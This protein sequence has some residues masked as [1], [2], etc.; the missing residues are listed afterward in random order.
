MREKARTEPITKANRSLADPVLAYSIKGRAF[1]DV[2]T[3][4]DV[5]GVANELAELIADTWGWN[6]RCRYYC[7]C[8]WSSLHLPGY[9]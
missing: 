9:H 8:C 1:V 3:R 5:A 4:D 2:Q 7:C 6:R